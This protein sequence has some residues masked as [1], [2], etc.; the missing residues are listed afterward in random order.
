M[1]FIL[2][3]STYYLGKKYLYIFVEKI[4]FKELVSIYVYNT[5]NKLYLKSKTI[6]I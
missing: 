4:S 6:I 3:T 1:Y 5:F 2:K